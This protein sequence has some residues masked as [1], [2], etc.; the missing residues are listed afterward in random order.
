MFRI[1]DPPNSNGYGNPTDDF[2]IPPIQVGDDLIILPFSYRE[3]ELAYGYPFIRL[4]DE[5]PTLTYILQFL[6]PRINHWWRNIYKNRLS[7]KSLY[8]FRMLLRWK[9]QPDYGLIGESPEFLINRELRHIDHSL[10]VS[11][12][13]YCKRTLN[14]ILFFNFFEVDISKHHHLIFSQLPE[15]FEVLTFNRESVFGEVKCYRVN[16][17]TLTLKRGTEYNVSFKIHGEL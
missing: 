7:N 16:V 8:D 14:N 9:N 11:L 2:F 5:V 17:N 15:E 12:K 10:E 6:R 13:L 3:G 1:I 4:S